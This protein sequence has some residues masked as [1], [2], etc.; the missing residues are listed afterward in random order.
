MKSLK[1]TPK[2]AVH[3]RLYDTT[4]TRHVETEKFCLDVEPEQY[5][6]Y[7]RKHSDIPELSPSTRHGEYWFYG[8]GVFVIHQHSELLHGEYWIPS[9]GEEHRAGRGVFARVV[10]GNIVLR[11]EEE[12]KK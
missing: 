1:K 7:L 6:A 2:T 3:T 12:K 4:G 9:D 10:D 11:K 5:M 8:L